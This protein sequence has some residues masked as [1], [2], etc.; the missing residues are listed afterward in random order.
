AHR[1][2]RERPVAGIHP[3]HLLRELVGMAALLPQRPGQQLRGAHLLEAG[4]AHAA[5]DVIL[6]HAV[7]GEAARVPE[8]HAR[9][10]LLLVEE[11]EPGAEHAVVVGIRAG[12]GTAPAAVEGDEVVHGG[13][14]VLPAGKR[15]S[16]EKTEAPSVAGGAS[17]S[18]CYALSPH[19]QQPGPPPTAVTL[20]RA[21][22]RMTF[23]MVPE[24]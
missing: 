21:T 6:H 11:I 4:L 5:A 17:G 1:L 18:L 8:H 10:L 2:E 14:P 22:V 20:M 16:P 7:D 3:E 15:R 24:R 19:A 12:S 9:P 13:S 23:C